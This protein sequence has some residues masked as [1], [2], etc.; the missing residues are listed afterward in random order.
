MFYIYNSKY[1]CAVYYI[2][3]LVIENITYLNNDANG[4]SEVKNRTLSSHKILSIHICES[5]FKIC[6]LYLLI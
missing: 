5:P 3:Q 1:M 6:N 2:S 4:K